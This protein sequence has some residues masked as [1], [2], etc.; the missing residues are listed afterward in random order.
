MDSA[1]YKVWSWLS[2]YECLLI[3]QNRFNFV[4]L[5]IEMSVHTYSVWFQTGFRYFSHQSFGFRSL[6]IGQS[7]AFGLDRW[8]LCKRNSEQVKNHGILS[9]SFFNGQFR[10]FN[11]LHFS[12]RIFFL[13]MIINPRPFLSVKMAFT[14]KPS[15]WGFFHYI[16]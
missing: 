1:R 9:V 11:L 12:H 8:L 6:W 15:G 2:N 13:Q 5:R 4:S 3:L 14:T 10:Q 7:W 16:E